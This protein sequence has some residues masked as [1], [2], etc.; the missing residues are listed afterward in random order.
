M[1]SRS[2]SSLVTAAG[3]RLWNDTQGLAIVLQLMTD[4]HI[5]QRI[6]IKEL[7]SLFRFLALF[8][9]PSNSFLK[10]LS[11]T[12]FYFPLLQ[13]LQISHPSHPKLK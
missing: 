2:L 8:D 7:N 9:L 6:G 12:G 13:S 1:Q 10:E 3:Y 5:A 4:S 11:R